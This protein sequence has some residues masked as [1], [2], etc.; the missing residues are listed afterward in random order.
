MPLPALSTQHPELSTIFDATDS[1]KPIRLQK[2][3]AQ[4]GIASR[5][6]AEE[7]VREGR[8]SVNGRVVTAMGERVDPKPTRF[9]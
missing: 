7:L 2:A 5:R 4:A 3:L 8:V 6:A 9:V 1:M